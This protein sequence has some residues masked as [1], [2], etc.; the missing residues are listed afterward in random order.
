MLTHK[1]RELENRGVIERTVYPVIP[2]KVE[3]KLTE[4][5]QSLKPVLDA[6]SEWSLKHD[7]PAK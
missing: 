2:P 1:L 3:Y 7:K 5:G 6:L 4:L